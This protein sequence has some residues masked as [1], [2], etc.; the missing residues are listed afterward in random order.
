MR[1]CTSTFPIDSSRNIRFRC[2]DA[3]A[4]VQGEVYK[5]KDTRLDRTVAV[6]VLPEHLAESPERKARFERE[7]KVISQLNHPHICTLYDVGEQDGINF[8]VMEYIEGETLAERLK[9]GA[10]PL[11]KVLEYGIQI[12]DGLDT[13]HRVGIVH[14]D[15]KPANAMLT[16][17]GVKLLDFGLARLVEGDV[18][19]ASS[20]APTQQKDL[21]KEESIIGT[22][23]YMAPEQLERKAADARTDIF[24]FGA[25]LYEMITGKKVFEGKTQASLITAIMS[26]E[27]RPLSEFQPLSPVALERVVRKCLAKNRDRRWQTASDLKDELEWMREGSGET[28]PMGRSARKASAKRERL[29]WVAALL[30][31]VVVTAAIVQGLFVPSSPPPPVKRFV[32]PLPPNVSLPRNYG[33]LLALSPNGTKIIFVGFRDEDSLIFLHTL[34][35]GESRALVGTEGAR[36]P[37]FSPDGEFIAFDA[38]GQLFRLALAGGPRVALA[39][40]GTY[41]AWGPDGSLFFWRGGIWRIPVAGG[42]PEA[43]LEW[44][45]GGN[46]RLKVLP[47]GKGVLFE[48]A[49]EP[50]VNTLNVLSLDNGERRTLVTTGTNPHY[51]ATGH[52]LFARDGSLFAVPF[53]VDGLRLTGPERPILEDLRVESGGAAQFVVGG[54]GSL[55]YAREGKELLGN[56]VW[57]DRQG[58]SHPVTGGKHRFATPRL[59]PDGRRVAVTITDSNGTDIWV[60]EIGRD[61]LTRLT[62]EEEN[63]DPIWSPDGK[64]I[65]F[66]RRTAREE[67]V[68]ATS[69]GGAGEMEQ[70][71]AGGGVLF[72]R[73][74]R[75]TGVS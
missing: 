46:G 25:M 11:D 7:A 31:S 53:D 2:T 74:G 71:S 29:A 43:L 70:L 66:R 21:T 64:R 16:K 40:E 61:I 1:P 52:I 33:S 15:V 24:A 5:A 48:G 17:S 8:I 20:D 4:S 23:Q 39:E 22:L 50:S 14:R 67:E 58:N 34:D 45:P 63:Y 10:L 30:A 19:S 72:P 28:A 3:S 41:P 9:K 59:S 44:E 56:L 47:N 73:R 13:A 35:D 68:F 49:D 60:H 42:P 26:S 37:A 69:A 18:G 65:A 6:K 38:Q 57:V 36:H 55:V 75:P 51:V 54:D 62:F 27:P 32:V 12:A